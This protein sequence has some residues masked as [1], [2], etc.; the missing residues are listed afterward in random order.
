MLLQSG[1]W[2]WLLP[3]LFSCL[4]D[5]ST[6]IVAE[7]G[8]SNILCSVGAVDKKILLFRICMRCMGPSIFRKSLSTSS[9]ALCTIFPTWT[10]LVISKVQKFKKFTLFMY[11]VRGD[12][13]QGR[14]LIK[15][16][17]YLKS[18]QI[19]FFECPF[20]KTDYVQV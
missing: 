7:S 15:E 11:W 9:L 10:K 1:I 14:I 8:V 5:T 3:F 6:Y 18:T 20:K 19:C 13:I 16:I 17:R 2:L 12:I 4:P